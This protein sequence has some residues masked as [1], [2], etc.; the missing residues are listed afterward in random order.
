M[1]TKIF[2]SKVRILLLISLTVLVAW[3]IVQ[4]IKIT[5]R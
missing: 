1:T 5:M 4:I 3:G 2:W